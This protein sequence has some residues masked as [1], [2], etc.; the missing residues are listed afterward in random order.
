MNPEEGELRPQLLDRFALA[1]EVEGLDD[2]N[3]RAEVVRR[4]IAFESDPVGFLADWR[5]EEQAERLR[6]QRAQELL[7]EV[8][9]DDRML[10][11]ITQLCVDFDVDGLRADIVMYKTAITPGGLRRA[12]PVDEGDVRDAAE[13]ALLHRRR[14]L[15]FQQPQL[16]RDLLDQKIREH[17]EE[18][19]DRDDGRHEPP[20]GRP[21]TPAAV[22]CRSP[23]A[24]LRERR[25]VP[26]D[27]PRVAG[28]SQHAAGGV[29]RPAEQGA[30]PELLG[31]L[32]RL[33]AA[34][35]GAGARPGAGRDDPSARR[36]SDPRE[37]MRGT[38]P[39][40]PSAD[41]WRNPRA[42]AA[43]WP[44]APLLAWDIRT[45]VRETGWGI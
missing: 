38:R 8:R 34:A 43:H 44:C 6:V 20:D 9:L 13:L 3:A 33:R 17:L 2:P 10:R 18:E 41:Q 15:P 14:R 21:A 11:L 19:D 32:R 36:I 16:D 25:A 24:G 30:Q 22:R 27:P 26:R 31:S 5:R 1:V 28:R 23:G 45:K 35:R 39:C 29:S 42:R 12:A 37:P 7:P 4:R 40:S